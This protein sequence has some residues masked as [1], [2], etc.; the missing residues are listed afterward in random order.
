LVDQLLDLSLVRD[1]GLNKAGRSRRGIDYGGDRVAFGLTSSG[2]DDGG[3]F[4]GKGDG[5]GFSDARR[6]VWKSST[7]FLN[8]AP[9][10]A[11]GRVE[12]G[13]AK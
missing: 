7:F 4:A 2:E 8:F 12:G 11:G 9:P 13:G 10:S 5:G 1:V 6:S 3:T